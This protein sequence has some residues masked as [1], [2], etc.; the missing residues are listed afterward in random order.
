MRIVRDP[1]ED[2]HS[3][4]KIDKWIFYI[5]V[6]TIMLVPLLI[7][8]KVTEIISPLI[9]NNVLLESGRKVDLFTYLKFITLFILTF[10]ALV[11]FLYKLY[12]LDYRLPQRKILWFFV[13]F[14]IAITISTLFSP[15]ISIALFGQYN[16]TDGAISYICYTLLMFISMH[17]NYPKKIV[18]YV[19]YAF[20]PLVIINFV[21]TT[22]NFFDHDILQYK[23]VQNALTLSF[24]DGI[25]LNEGSELVGTLNHWN[26]MSG[27]FSV[28]TVMLLAWAIVDTKTIRKVINF[29][30]ALLSITTMLIAMSA[31]G[32][33]TFICMVPILIWLTFKSL[34]KKISVITL[35]VFLVLT[36]SII[37]LL[38][39]KDPEAWDESIGFFVS[40]NPYSEEQSTGTSYESNFKAPLLFGNK[41]SAA[42]EKF[43]LPVLPENNWGAGTGR[44]YIWVETLKLLQD[45]PLFGYGLDTLMYNF[46]HYNIEAQGNL[47]ELTIVDKPHN[48][49]MGVLYGTGVMGF[50]GFMGIIIN[51]AWKSLKVILRYNSSQDSFLIVLCIAW[52][53]FLIQALFND[54]LPGT[55]SPLFIVAGIIGA[56]FYKVEV[57]N[58]ESNTN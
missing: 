8:G 30:F 14:L 50:I 13:I 19:I 5:I 42:E 34:N 10:L 20:Y 56:L 22:M 38:S 58:T 15:T 40:V 45:R 29:I 31:S 52:T 54:S 57:Q 7:G 25:T 24:P 44:I 49:Y 32:F 27:M 46:P 21:I 51:I 17:I 11:L 36:G 48:F 39:I 55:T 9:D 4:E 1:I 26:Y 28:I 47:N 18:E 2:E 23:L 3:R 12:F 33:V 37:H 43:S 53:A 6:T 35:T 41:V 16:R